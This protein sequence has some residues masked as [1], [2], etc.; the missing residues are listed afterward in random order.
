MMHRHILFHEAAG[1]YIM[2]IS[3]DAD[4]DF[5]E[6]IDYLIAKTLVDA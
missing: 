4:I 6:V 2:V 1:I 3:P 5:L